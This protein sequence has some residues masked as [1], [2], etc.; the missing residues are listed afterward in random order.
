[1]PSAMEGRYK[2]YELLKELDSQI[3][4]TMSQVA[5][6]RMSRIE[7]VQT[8]KAHRTAF[9]EWIRFADL[10]ADEEQDPIRGSPNEM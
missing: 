10:Q 2:A 5:Y 1:M 4:T 7:W 6:G 8:C 3:S 9:D